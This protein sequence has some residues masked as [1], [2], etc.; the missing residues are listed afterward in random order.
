METTATG[1]RLTARGAATRER[2]L[3]TAADIIRARGVA[4]TTFEE[5]CAASG[6]S[7]SQMYQHFPDKDALVRAVI[8]LRAQEVMAREQL[9]LD[10]LNSLRGLERWRDALVSSN[11]VARGAYGCAIGSLASELSDQDE[12]ARQALEQVFE[13]WQQLLSDGLARMKA[14]G[15]L[16]EDADPER[17]A[18]GIMAALQGGYL[19]AQTAH[20]T[21]PMAIALDMALDHVR[22]VSNA[23]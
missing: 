7:K 18:T 20:D 19:L 8:E 23:V 16:S 13:A 9:R 17:L 14:K 22:A 11:A 6:S 12:I 1:R 2:I 5:V 3:R 4:A 10:R 15:A 21:E